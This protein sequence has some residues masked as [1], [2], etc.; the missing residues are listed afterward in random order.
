MPKAKGRLFDSLSETY[1]SLGVHGEGGTGV[2][3]RVL[4]SRGELHA[5]KLLRRE[6]VTGERRRRFKNEMQFCLRQDHGSDHIVPVED[7]GFVI[8]E[9]VKCPFYVMPFFDFT[10]RKLIASGIEPNDVLTLFL[11]ILDGV[12][13]AHRC[14]VFHR[15][16]KPENVLCDSSMQAI[17][18]DFGIAHFGE[19]AIHTFVDTDGASRL[20]NFMYAAPEQRMRGRSVDHRADIYSLGVILN[21][22]FTQDVLQG[23]GYKTIASVAPNFGFLDPLVDQMV[24]QDPTDRPASTDAIRQKITVML[25]QSQSRE[26]VEELRAAAEQE[27]VFDDP[28]VREPVR[29]VDR[30]WQRGYLVVTLQPQPN[31]A[32]V[33]AFRHPSK[34]PHR[35]QGKPPQAFGFGGGS[36]ARIQ[37][38]EAEAPRVYKYFCEYVDLANETYKGLRERQAEDERR[39]AERQ[40][41]Q[42]IEEEERRQRVLASLEDA[43]AGDDGA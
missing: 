24:R 32:W 16:L 30:D 27:A 28:L 23:T 20:A 8:Q 25:A 11:G 31:D 19:A 39:K 21:E 3:H 43:S 4:D 33:S 13:A 40:L 2:V 5:L 12:H 6:Y 35:V 7:T 26:K 34:A 29:V 9:N 1:T 14:G 18:A 38:T 36:S 15:D 42:H 22:M 37:A 41:R 17:V 10:L